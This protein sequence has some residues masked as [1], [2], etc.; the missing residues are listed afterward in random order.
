MSPEG[1]LFLAAA[2]LL[3]CCGAGQSI[4]GERYIFPR[5]PASGTSQSNT[6]PIRLLRIAWHLGSSI[7]VVFGV[8]FFLMAQAPLSAR[9]VSGVFAVT[10]FSAFVVTGILSRGRYLAWPI[11]LAVSLI[12]FWGTRTL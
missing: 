7:W 11:F 10:F 5:L 9:A 1:L 12:A 4:L 6:V 8:L 2:L 3:I